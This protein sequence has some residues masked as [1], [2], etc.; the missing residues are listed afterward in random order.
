MV[1][2]VLSFI[3]DNLNAEKKKNSCTAAAVPHLKREMV[4]VCITEHISASCAW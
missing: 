3:E 2:F 1:T 4:T